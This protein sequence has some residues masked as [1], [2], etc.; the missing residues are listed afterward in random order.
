MEQW[1]QLESQ[2]AP[3]T[4]ELPA[5]SRLGGDLGMFQDAIEDFNELETRFQANFYPAV[6]TVAVPGQTDPEPQ[7]AAGDPFRSRGRASSNFQFA[8]GERLPFLPTYPENPEV[9]QPGERVTGQGKL[10][11][12]RVPVNSVHP[13]RSNETG[14]QDVSAPARSIPPNGESPFSAQRATNTP[15][16]LSGHTGSLNSHTEA[17]QKEAPRPFP[18]GATSGPNQLPAQPSRYPETI[19]QRPLQGLGDFASGFTPSVA[20]PPNGS[21]ADRTPISEVPDP[22]APLP[23][24]GTP[25]NAVPSAPDRLQTAASAEPAVTNRR[26]AAMPA[27][28]HWPETPVPAVPMRPGDPAF[29]FSG[30]AEAIIQALTRQVVRDFKRYY[31]D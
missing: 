20:V 27:V 31:P 21:A 23:Q 26:E 5:L 18:N 7:P 6:D 15:G 1:V 17:V 11:V 29:D 19:W 14:L 4:T 2:S 22:A 8:S 16:N 24:H 12:R 10:P 25:P 9:E 30:E 13:D 3:G 28:V